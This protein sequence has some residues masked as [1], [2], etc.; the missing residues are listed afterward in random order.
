MDVGVE[1]SRAWGFVRVVQVKARPCDCG[2]DDV[3][4]ERHAVRED[5]EK[6]SMQSRIQLALCWTAAFAFCK[7]CKANSPIQI[8]SVVFCDAP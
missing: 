8:N 5:V 2:L 3:R 6:D 4:G 7:L 1:W